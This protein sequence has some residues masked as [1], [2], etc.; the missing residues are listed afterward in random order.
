MKTPLIRRA[1]P[2]RERGV[3]MIFVALAMAAIISMAALAI[4]VITLYLAKQEAQRAADAAALAA[5]KVISLSGITGD[6]LNGSGHWA[7]ICGPD[8]GNNGL[9]TRA[10]KAVANQ[11]L[12]AGGPSTNPIVMYSSGGTSNADCT[13]LSGTG[14]GVNPVITVQLTRA[15]L[16]TF[17][18]RIWGNTGNTISATAAAEV[19][20]PSNSGNSGSQPTGTIIPV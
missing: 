11:N 1:Q 20:N 5:G 2:Q 6:P 13:A 4:D 10:A 12:I 19:F 8:D 16:P 14:F 15:S 3:T 9:A 7:S 17:F 18:S